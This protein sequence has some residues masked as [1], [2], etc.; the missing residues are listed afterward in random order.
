M[1]RTKKLQAIILA[2]GLGTRLRGVVGEL[3]KPLAP[4]DGVPFLEYLLM[5][6]KAQGIGEFILCVGHG[7]KLIRDYLGSGDQLGLTIQYTIEEKLLGTGG[8]IKLAESHING[9]FLV[10][11]GDTYFEVDLHTMF[12]SHKATG[13]RATMALARREDTSRYGRVEFD[14]NDRILSFVEKAPDNGPGHINGGIYIF[15]KEVFDSIPTGT[16]CSLERE[17][18]PR[19]IGRGLHGFTV[20]GYFIDIGIPE[21]YARAKRELPARRCT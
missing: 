2:G 17:V 7:G 5:R 1:K 8:A 3:P 14:K 4:I 20:D 11:N 6:F 10:A 18:L 19:L 13:A 21:D 9:D 16:V 15:G 12:N